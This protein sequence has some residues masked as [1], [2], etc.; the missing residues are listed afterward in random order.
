MFWN[1][2]FGTA[3][4]RNFWSTRACFQQSY[5]SLLKKRYL[6][7][8]K[9]QNFVSQLLPMCIR[10]L[11]ETRK[12]KIDQK[13]SS[14]VTKIIDYYF[15]FLNKSLT[16]CLKSGL[17][18]LSL[19][20]EKHS[21]LEQHSHL[22]HQSLHFTNHSD[23]AHDWSNLSDSYDAF[24]QLLLALQMEFHDLSLLEGMIGL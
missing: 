12:I 10:T 4:F 2:N 23:D 13:P 14:M 7:L 8:W 17:A 5:A 3:A 11:P 18:L 15:L 21:L 24:E 1:F 6:Q 22:E 16:H 19:H 9:V 20:C